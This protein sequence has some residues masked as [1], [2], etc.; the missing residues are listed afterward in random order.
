MKSQELPGV[1]DCVK[2]RKKEKS[3]KLTVNL[4]VKFR[5]LVN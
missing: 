4:S 3:Q 1:N 2:K 5:R